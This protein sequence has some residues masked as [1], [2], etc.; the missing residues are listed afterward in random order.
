MKPRERYLCTHTKPRRGNTPFTA[1]Y[2]NE[3]LCTGAKPRKLNLT[4]QLH[5]CEATGL[6]ADR[7]EVRL[8]ALD[9]APLDFGKLQEL[10]RAFRFAHQIELVPAVLFF[11]QN[12]P[13]GIVSAQRR[14]DLEP[15]REFEEQLDVFAGIQCFGENAPSRAR[16][17]AC[18]VGSFDGLGKFPGF[19]DS[20]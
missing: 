1:K 12:R 20:P 16:W 8:A 10:G 18:S 17:G 13:V 2:A 7:L 6:E 5:P 19:R 9:L 4:C 14:F 15:V 3:I 11:L